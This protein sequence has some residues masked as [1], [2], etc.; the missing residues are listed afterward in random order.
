M[1]SAPDE[2]GPIGGKSMVSSLGGIADWLESRSGMIDS[3]GTRCMTAEPYQPDTPLYNSRIISNY[4]KFIERNYSHIDIDELLSDAQ[5][6]RYQVED[7]QG[8]GVGP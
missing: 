7:E 5:L 4:V 3:E 2:N 1:S 6:E 8:Q